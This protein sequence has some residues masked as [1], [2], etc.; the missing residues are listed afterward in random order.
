MIITFCYV[1]ESNT[2]LLS[3]LKSSVTQRGLTLYFEKLLN[4]EKCQVQYLKTNNDSEIIAEF[5]TAA[6]WYK[7]RRSFKSEASCMRYCAFSYKPFP[8]YLKCLMA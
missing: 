5:E 2:V 3:G 6:G 1:E 7:K 4:N 8:F